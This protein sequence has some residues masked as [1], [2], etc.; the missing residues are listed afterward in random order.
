MGR[1]VQ[2]VSGGYLVAGRVLVPERRDSV[3]EEPGLVSSAARMRHRRVD[4]VLVEGVPGH[5]GWAEQVAAER[6]DERL[7]DLEPRFG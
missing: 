6:E 5:A 7:A 2:W 1:I 4:A 3:E